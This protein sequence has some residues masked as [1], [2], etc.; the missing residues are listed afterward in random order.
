MT[1][2]HNDS[3]RRSRN[4]LLAEFDI[5]ASPGPTL[6]NTMEV[7]LPVGIANLRCYY[8]VAGAGG[9]DVSFEV[10]GKPITS[11]TWD[12]TIDDVNAQGINTAAYSS[13]IEKCEQFRVNY[14]ARTG[15]FTGTST[16]KVWIVT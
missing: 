6:S 1:S 7:A 16:L 2:Q 9:T 8:E 4:V 15:V 14:S 3:F 11:V 13:N 10:H 12:T 5:T